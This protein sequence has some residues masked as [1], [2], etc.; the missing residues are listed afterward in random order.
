MAA[1]SPALA[2]A[3]AVGAASRG[4]VPGRVGDTFSNS[5]A[6][7][8]EDDP[9]LPAGRARRPRVGS[10]QHTTGDG[11]DTDEEDAEHHAPRGRGFGE[12]WCPPAASVLAA[13]SSTALAASARGSIVQSS[14]A[15]APA[16]AAANGQGNNARFRPEHFEADEAS[17]DEQRPGEAGG[18]RQNGMIVV[19]GPS[20]RNCLLFLDHVFS[21]LARRHL[22][23]DGGCDVA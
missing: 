21:E 17:E 3:A 7:A 14:S 8:F 13:S 4:G 6:E 11:D 20:F 10:R 16:S 9:P 2:S 15:A 19:I 12:S 22:D 5:E 23:P 1:T 18:A